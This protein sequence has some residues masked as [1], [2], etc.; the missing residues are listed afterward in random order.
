MEVGCSRRRRGRH[1]VQDTNCQT[2]LWTDTNPHALRPSLILGACALDTVAEVIGSNAW[3]EGAS[4][5]FG[6]QQTGPVLPRVIVVQ[7]R[8]AA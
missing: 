3:V 7:A 6:M 4:K 5:G 1:V 2:K 8:A